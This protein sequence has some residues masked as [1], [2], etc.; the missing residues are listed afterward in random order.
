MLFLSRTSGGIGLIEGVERAG[1]GDGGLISIS[2][3]FSEL[4]LTGAG[5]VDGATGMTE[6]K[7]KSGNLSISSCGGLEVKLKLLAGLASVG[8]STLLLP[9]SA[10]FDLILRLDL[11]WGA[12]G[13]GGSGQIGLVSSVC[14]LEAVVSRTLTEGGGGLDPFSLPPAG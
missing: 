6:E 7:L 12:G 9:E 2:E 1:G 4:C 13:L 8:R 14:P 5:P 11:A 3:G 10:T